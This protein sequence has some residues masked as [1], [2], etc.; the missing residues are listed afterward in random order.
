MEDKKQHNS[1]R[2]GTLIQVESKSFSQEEKT[3]HEAVSFLIKGRDGIN[4]RHQTTKEK[5]VQIEKKSVKMEN[6]GSTS[7]SKAELKEE[8]DA[9]IKENIIVT[10]HKWSEEEEKK[11]KEKFGS[12]G[13][14]EETHVNNDKEK[15]KNMFLWDSESDDE[16]DYYISPEGNICPIHTLHIKSSG[17]GDLGGDLEEILTLGGGRILD[18]QPVKKKDEGGEQKHVSLGFR[19]RRRG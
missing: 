7:K 3:T 17:F 1:S 12:L 5:T 10:Y 2:N 16:D 18:H 6:G 8:R 11:L 15:D 9:W 19:V 4:Q 14:K 13:I